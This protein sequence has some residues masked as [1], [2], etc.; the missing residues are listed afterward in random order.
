MIVKESLMRMFCG[1]RNIS[2]ILMSCASRKGS[3]MGRSYG[4]ES[5]MCREGAPVLDG[6]GGI[7]DHMRSLRN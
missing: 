6:S 3:L 2:M 4:H 5:N 7:S 1:P